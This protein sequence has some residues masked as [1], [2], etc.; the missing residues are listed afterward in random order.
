MAVSVTELLK[1]AT[2]IG[3][4]AVASGGANCCNNVNPGSVKR[5]GGGG[6]FFFPAD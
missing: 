4:S 6:G 5:G 2:H 1:P 3:D